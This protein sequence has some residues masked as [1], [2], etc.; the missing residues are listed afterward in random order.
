MW[1]L[2][3]M[4]RHQNKTK[5]LVWEMAAAIGR[6]FDKVINYEVYCTSSTYEVSLD[7]SIVNVLCMKQNRITTALI[8]H[9]NLL[10]NISYR[11]TSF[12]RGVTGLIISIEPS[13]RHEPK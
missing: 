1:G 10:S 4:L 6:K 3:V 12:K 11:P 2:A 7:V 13:L 5:K 9:P 8:T